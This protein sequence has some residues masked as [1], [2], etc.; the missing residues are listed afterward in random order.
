MKISTKKFIGYASVITAVA[1]GLDMAETFGKIEAYTDCEMQLS[2]II[3]SREK[4][5]KEKAKDN[6]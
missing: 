2:R 4:N 5:R 6:E 3:E 1:L